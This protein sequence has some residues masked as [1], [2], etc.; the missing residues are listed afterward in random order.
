MFGKEE[1]RLPKGPEPVGI[2]NNAQH[3]LT[4]LES[5]KKSK[6]SKSIEDKV[7]RDD[8]GRILG[9]NF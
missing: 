6:R 1:R 3:M 8:S 5:E 4:P 9:L 2:E 7:I